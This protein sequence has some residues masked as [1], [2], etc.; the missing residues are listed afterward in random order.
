MNS[1][2]P[3]TKLT[4]TERSLGAPPQHNVWH[5]GGIERMTQTKKPCDLR[6][7]HPED[8]CSIPIWILCSLNTHVSQVLGNTEM[9][10]K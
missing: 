5:T 7:A 2:L 9:N 6:D 1:E 10:R 4:F 8:T 3:G